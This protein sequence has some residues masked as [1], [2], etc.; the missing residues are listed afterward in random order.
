MYIRLFVYAKFKKVA[1]DIFDNIIED[2]IISSVTI[3]KIEPY[4]KI[5][6]IYIIEASLDLKYKLK[7]NNLKIILNK[8]ADKWLF[9]GDPEDEALAS[10]N[11]KGCNY[12]KEHVK[13]INIFY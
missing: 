5:E 11:L 7:R 10:E 13:M 6:G 8:I 12:I 4:W 2:Y 1:L 9:F 3:N